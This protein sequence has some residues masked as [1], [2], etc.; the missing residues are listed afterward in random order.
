MRNRMGSSLNLDTTVVGLQG[1]PISPTGP[2]SGQALVFDGTN[3]TPTNVQ[4]TAPP[5]AAVGPTPPASPGSGDLWFNTTT[6]ILNVWNGSAWVPTYVDNDPFLPLAGG[7]LTGPLVLSGDAT[8]PLNPVTL[9]QLDSTIAGLPPPTSVGSTPPASPGT[10]DQWFNTNNNT[11][12]VWNGSAWVPVAPSTPVSLSG[13]QVPIVF[14]FP[15]KPAASFAIPIPIVIPLTIPANFAGSWFN[16]N[17][18]PTANT[19]FNVFHNTTSGGTGVGTITIQP[20][21]T[22]VWSTAGFTVSPQDTLSLIA[23]TTPDATIA[24]VA[25]TIL[26]T[27]T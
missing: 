16:I 6:G 3:W 22:V 27:R 5:P 15:G 7:T 9:Q 11:L 21:N 17:V 12:N 2:T 4:T 24:G 1:F 8:A 25:F 10:G 13:T 23:P 14:F 26:A 19:V 20:P 18:A